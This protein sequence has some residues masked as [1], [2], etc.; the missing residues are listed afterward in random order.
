MTENYLDKAMFL[1][2][3]IEK[4]FKN[5]VDLVTPAINSKFDYPWFA[6]NFVLYRTYN[7]VYEYERGYYSI[8]SGNQE[9][10]GITILFSNEYK[11][12]FNNQSIDKSVISSNLELLDHE[13]RLR[14]PDKFL[15][16][17]Q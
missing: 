17:F 10:S 7:F 12:N 9:S 6:V 3:I 16:L 1:S 8:F 15:S 2:S 11:K 5:K 4:H 13:I 14:L